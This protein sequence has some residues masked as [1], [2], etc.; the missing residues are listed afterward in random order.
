[1]WDCTFVD[2]SEPSEKSTS[3]D[4]AILL[5]EAQHLHTAGSLLLHTPQDSIEGWVCDT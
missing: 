4:Y 1:M 5:P 2:E 3:V